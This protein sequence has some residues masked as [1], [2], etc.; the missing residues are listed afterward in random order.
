MK[1]L[2]LIGLI[3]ASSGAHA[4]FITTTPM[5]L[6]T[7]STNTTS[8]NDRK[9]V[10]DQAKE[11]AATFIGSNGQIQGAYLTRALEMLRQENPGLTATDA[12]IAN[13]ILA[14]E[15]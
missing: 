5:G 3:L 12:D 7:Y 2:V 14:S 1:K 9:L 6:P 13:A 10:I 11:D 4:F 15:E 8:G